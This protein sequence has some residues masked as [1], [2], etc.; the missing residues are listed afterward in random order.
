[1]SVSHGD[2]P[3]EHDSLHTVLTDLTDID[4]SRSAFEQAAANPATRVI[5]NAGATFEKPLEEV[6]AGDLDAVTQLH[7]GSA[8]AMVQATCRP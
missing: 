2:R 4:S 3:F 1:M 6:T 5:H 8:I 7:L